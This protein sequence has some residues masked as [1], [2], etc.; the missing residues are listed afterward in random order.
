MKGIT[1]KSQTTW[2][3]V[4]QLHDINEQIEKF[5]DKSFENK[6]FVRQLRE[7]KEQLLEFLLNLSK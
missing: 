5:S 1:D 4:M 2:W 6:D 7:R 3:A